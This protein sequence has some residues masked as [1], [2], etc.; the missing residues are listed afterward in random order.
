M[1]NGV[2]EVEVVG[3]IVCN[4][5][6]VSSVVKGSV[7]GVHCSVVCLGRENILG[8]RGSVARLQPHRK[9]SSILCNSVSMNAIYVSQ[10]LRVD[11]V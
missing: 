1:D 6:S 2:S 11:D 4:S 8:R 10:S 3:S 7:T 5:W 9:Q